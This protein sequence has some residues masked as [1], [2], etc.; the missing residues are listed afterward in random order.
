MGK[1][2]YENRNDIDKKYRWDLEKMYPNEDLWL[3]DISKAETLT[4]EFLQRKGKVMDN[5]RSLL[6]ALKAMDDIGLLIEK[7]FVYARMKMDEDNRDSHRQAMFDKINTSASKILSALSFLTPEILSSEEKTVKM[8]IDENP[9]LRVYR[10]MLEGIFNRKEHILSEKEENLLANLGQVTSAPHS[11]FNILNN[12]DL[13]FGS[14]TDD[15]GNEIEITHGNYINFMESHNREVR[16]AAFERM[17]QTYADMINLIGTT[18]S[19]SVKTDVVYSQ[20]RKYSSARDSAL[21]RD[22]IPESVYD[23][24]INVVSSNLSNLHRYMKL[25]KDELGVDELKMWDIYVPLVK[26][27]ERNIPFEEGVDIMLKALKPL[28][29]EYSNALKKGVESRWIDVY[30]TP[31][32]TSGAYSFGSYDSMPYS[33]MNY[34]DTLKDVFTL[35]H[36]MGHSMHSFFTRQTQPYV[37]G[38]HSIFTAEVAST[39]NE[40]LLIRYLLNQNPDDEMKK[41]LLNFYLEEFRGTLF[42]QTMF[43]EFEHKC[44]SFVESGGSLTPD[45][46]N[47][48]Y[49][50]LNRKYY[51]KVVGEDD[52]IKYEWAKIPHFYRAYYVYQYA[53]GFSAATAI[54]KK[55]LE[56]GEKERNDYLTFLTLGSSKYPVDLLKIAGVDMSS[57]EPVKKA[58]ETFNALLDEF[59]TLKK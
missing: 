20:V 58:M 37:Y 7:A 48:E 4:E 22:K 45:W 1:K 11:I 56:G 30:E 6:E 32:K 28:G 14:I 10:H 9:G 43:A 52:Y 51:G 26:L 47:T 12:S 42:R 31:G 49:E 36:E 25:R 24:L 46:L 23:N 57:P 3:K 44:H 21:S 15:Y 2:V 29:Q 53:T 39:V 33:L 50:N 27:P 41:Y 13:K 40:S 17:Y 5:S 8:F 18:Y 34:T 38:D 55:I 59:E 35:V 19:Y 16:K 54:S